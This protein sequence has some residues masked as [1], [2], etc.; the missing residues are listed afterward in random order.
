MNNLNW[1]QCQSGNTSTDLGTKEP[2]RHFFG[3]LGKWLKFLLDPFSFHTAAIRHERL[4]Y[5]KLYPL[6]SQPMPLVSQSMPLVS[7]ILSPV[8]QTRSS[9]PTNQQNNHIVDIY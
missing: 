2:N 5:Y 8:L 6:V 4:L 1:T 9:W 7:Q 3:N